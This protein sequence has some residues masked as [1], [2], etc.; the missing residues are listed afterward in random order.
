MAEVSLLKYVKNI[1]TKLINN[2]RWVS[3]NDGILNSYNFNKYII[4]KKVFNV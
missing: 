4:H 3:C 2:W 1:V